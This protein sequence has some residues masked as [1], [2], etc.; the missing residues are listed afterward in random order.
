VL[1]RHLPVE[2]GELTVPKK[3]SVL[4]AVRQGLC[5]SKC[6]V[7]LVAALVVTGCSNATVSNDQAFI[8]TQ[9]D[10]FTQIGAQWL[11]V[12]RVSD[13]D[14]MLMVS[15]AESFGFLDSNPVRV[16]INGIPVRVAQSKPLGGKP[17]TIQ[18]VNGKLLAI[19]SDHRIASRTLSQQP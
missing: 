7:V 8:L 6:L 3:Y 19:D 2:V 17:G 14:D 11:N 1:G 10:L 5:G 15:P 9:S 13:D 18:I 4:E 12:P 16:S